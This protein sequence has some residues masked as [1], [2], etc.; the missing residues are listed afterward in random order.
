MIQRI[1]IL[2]TIGVLIF[3]GCSKQVLVPYQDV[4]KNNWVTITLNSGDQ[5]EGHVLRAEPH[6]IAIRN[7]EGRNLAVE[8][9][10]IQQVKR[11]PPEYDDFGNAISEREIKEKQ[12]NKNTTI[13][14]IGGGLLSFG[15]SFFI[16]SMISQN[17]EDGGTVLAAT[18]GAGGILGTILFIQAGKKQD[19]KEAVRKIR[20]SRQSKQIRPRS[21]QKTADEKRKEESKKLEELRRQHEKLLRE[22]EET[23]RKE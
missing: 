9:S 7:R 15:T 21:Q 10:R 22:L 18:T 1:A 2:I 14:G 17:A 8:V 11:I 13:Y 3:S 5:V 12:S 19:R 20:A 16:G 6:L 4:E 23:K